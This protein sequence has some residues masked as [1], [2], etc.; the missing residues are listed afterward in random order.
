MV[1]KKCEYCGKEFSLSPS[2]AAK[3][4]CCSM[5]C[6]TRL[7]YKNGVKFG[8][9]KGHESFEGCEKTWFTSEKVKGEN[10][11]NYKDGS[12]MNEGYPAEF[13]RIRKF[14]F[15]LMNYTCDICE[16]QIKEQTP[17]KHLVAH[18]RDMN[19]Y[20]NQLNNLRVLCNSCHRKL[21]NEIRRTGR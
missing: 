14:I 19:I 13:K 7:K 5:S 3:R 17:S 1:I 11:T 18:H 2:H 16:K 8:F 9:Q 10:N 21:H 6:G 15:P 12:R 4:K 20:N